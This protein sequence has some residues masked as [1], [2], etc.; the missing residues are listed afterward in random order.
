MFRRTHG[1]LP[2][3]EKGRV[4]EG[5]K[6]PRDLIPT[7]LAALADLPFSRGGKPNAITPPENR[8]IDGSAA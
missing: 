5:I 2:P 3:L 6:L 8:Q 1:A 4:G 7:R